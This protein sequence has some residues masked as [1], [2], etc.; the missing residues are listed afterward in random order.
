MAVT[1]AMAATVPMVPVP[2]SSV[3]D[4]WPGR[5]GILLVALFGLIFG[6]GS[7]QSQQLGGSTAG[8]ATG[9][10]A[11]TAL[12]AAGD[13]PQPAGVYL[14]PGA[15]GGFTPPGSVG[16]ALGGMAPG[17]T[18]L[19]QYQGVTDVF[20]TPYAG[21][22]PGGVLPP[23]YT[24]VPSITLGIMGNSNAYQSTT[25][26]TRGDVWLMA[27]PGILATANT[28]R[29]IGSV[30]YSP[31]F[32]LSTFEA[33]KNSGIYQTFN[34]TGRVNILPERLFI[35]VMGMGY[36]NNVAGGINPSLSIQHQ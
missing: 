22:G 24:F 16:T 19:P 18:G 4:G 7:A 8:A 31:S 23:G 35:N 12:G 25:G 17:A 2:P 9:G 1:E 34:V 11:G 5:G 21:G 28:P 30:N 29:V 32:R 26:K 3:G 6:A 10:I 36:T 15:G 20:G 14:G 27:T 33:G 13:Q